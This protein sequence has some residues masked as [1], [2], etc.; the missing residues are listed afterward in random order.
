MHRRALF[1]QR[2]LLSMCFQDNAVHAST[3]HF[4]S[5]LQFLLVNQ[6]LVGTQVHRVGAIL[7]PGVGK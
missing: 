7:P 1:K 6:L 2:E 5:Y 4:L 3:Y